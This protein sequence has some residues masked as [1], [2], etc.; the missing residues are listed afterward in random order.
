VIGLALL[1]FSTNA[2]AG[3]TTFTYNCDSD[4]TFNHTNAGGKQDV[5]VVVSD[6][7]CDEDVLVVVPGPKKS[8]P[9]SINAPP[10]ETTSVSVSLKNGQG[11][12][13]GLVGLSTEG[14]VKITLILP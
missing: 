14:Q 4:F 8:G 6:N 2:S 5:T 3:G 13:A 12:T 9:T 10:G 11:V 7:E 1:A